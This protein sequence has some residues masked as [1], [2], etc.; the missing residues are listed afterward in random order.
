[1]GLKVD[2]T[3]GAEGLTQLTSM[4]FKLDLPDP[5]DLLDLL[6]LLISPG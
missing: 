1:M 2:T 5:P 6:D 4:S 3:I